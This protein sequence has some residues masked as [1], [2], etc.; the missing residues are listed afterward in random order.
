M[1]KGRE[2][3]KQIK[4]EKKRDKVK[5][6]MVED[7]QKKQELSG[8]K[9]DWIQ[10]QK[11]VSDYVID[12]VQL[13]AEYEMFEAEMT[14]YDNKHPEKVVM[15]WNGKVVSKTLLGA[16]MDRKLNQ[17]KGKMAEYKQLEERLKSLGMTDEQFV[18]LEKGGP[19][20]KEMSKVEKSTKDTP[21]YVG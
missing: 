15:I 6:K 16:W 9:A 13:K 5:N 1:G 2:V 3:R 14:H 20:I 7:M 8:R 4:T 19:I 10:F 11:A 12:L 18:A 21:N 17:Y